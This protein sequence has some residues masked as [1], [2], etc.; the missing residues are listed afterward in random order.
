MPL[1]FVYTYNL[2][3]SGKYKMKPRKTIDHPNGYVQTVYYGK[4]D[5]C[6]GYYEG[7]GEKFCGN[8]CS[9]RNRYE[10]TNKIEI[11][12]N[13][14]DV[15]E[16]TL[17]SDAHLELGNKNRNINPRYRFKQAE[18]SKEY[19][20]YVAK[21]F[22]L[23]NKIVHML[24]KHKPT[25]LVKID[26]IDCRFKTCSSKDLQKYHQRWYINK[27][28]IIPEDFDPNPECLL[29]G[30]LGDGYLYKGNMKT[31]T[32]PYPVFCTDSF[33][34]EDLQN[35]FI[36]PLENNYGIYARFLWYKGRPRIA[37]RRKSFD[38]FFNFIGPCPVSCFQYKWPEKFQKQPA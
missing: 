11:D 26:T 8:S 23:E 17:F 6:G 27:I 16:G 1:F 35:S 20:E 19:V 21:Y 18:K 37:I 9:V 14:H 7:A 30:Y 34:A 15:I 33:T 10:T 12:K 32:Y 38:D 31:Y 25:D 28:K 36:D 2:A 24:N 22:G 29:H 4:C 3:Y 13:T 5:Y